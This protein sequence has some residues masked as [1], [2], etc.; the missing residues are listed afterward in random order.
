MGELELNDGQSLPGKWDQV[1]GSGCPGV[2]Q[3]V[4][5]VDAGLNEEEDTWSSRGH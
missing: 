1:G 2:C 5:A 3:G 4:S